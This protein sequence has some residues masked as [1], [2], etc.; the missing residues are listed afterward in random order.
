LIL[1]QFTGEIKMD[2]YE[3]AIN[4]FL[5]ISG[6]NAWEEMQILF[7]RIASAKPY[8]WS[9]P[10]R[11]CETIGG[12]PE[13]A[14]PAVIAMGCSHISIILVDDMLDADPRGEYQRIGAPAAANLACAF[15]AA[16]LEAIVRSG[17]EPAILSIALTSFNRMYLMT[18]LGQSWDVKCPIDETAYW[19]IVQTKSSPFFGAALQIG[20]L[21][22]GTSIETAG[23]L[24][25]L[26]NL[27][28]EM[29]QIHDDLSDTLAVPANP[30]WLQGRSPLPIL[31]AKVVDHPER[32][33]F[34]ELCGEISDENALQEAQDILV[35][36]GAVSYCMDQLL[37][38]YQSAQEALQA[39]ELARP[40]SIESLLDE[41]IA[42][43]WKLFDAI[44][45]SPPGIA[46]P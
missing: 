24:K 12:T 44:E 29:I 41:V 38:R 19:R 43:V 2:I 16:G 4:G 31:F 37:R 11:A 33:R 30:D 26:G 23:K 36:C 45:V 20:A 14:V 27:Y 22:G 18:A 42:P 3:Q 9:L 35:R 13:Q 32:S 17:V 40:E 7:Q 8:H 46:T 39:A 1:G 28:G 5:G 15:Q 6:V 21:L 25:E 34:L 10:V